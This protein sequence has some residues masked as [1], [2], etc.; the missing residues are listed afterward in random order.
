MIGH[1][2]AFCS[3]SLVVQDTFTDPT[4]HCNSTAVLPQLASVAPELQC[5]QHLNTKMC[6]QLFAFCCGLKSDRVLQECS[7]FAVTCNALERVLNLPAASHPL[8]MHGPG[9]SIV[10]VLDIVMFWDACVTNRLTL[11]LQNN[12]FFPGLGELLL[13]LGNAGNVRGAVLRL[14]RLAQSSL[15]GLLRRLVP[16]VCHASAFCAN[17]WAFVT[18]VRCE[19][20]GSARQRR[21]RYSGSVH[22]LHGVPRGG[23]MPR[24]FDERRNCPSVSK[25]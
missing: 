13:P 10:L 1:V 23:Q 12:K 2:L 9:L 24:C 20:A 17:P 25:A 4:L 16:A 6:A 8:S 3:A 5:W 15:Q 18:S 7:V 11:D 21:P 19:R 22:K 14:P